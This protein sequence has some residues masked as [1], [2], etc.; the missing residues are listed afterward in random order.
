VTP[1]VQGLRALFL[2]PARSRRS[3]PVNARKAWS[4]SEER[5]YDPEV[6]GREAGR[7]ELTLDEIMAILPDTPRRIVALTEGR[8]PAQLH[9]APS[10]DGWSV[11]D[12]LA[13]LRAC[14]DVLGGNVLRILA[15][16][17]PAW[18]GMNPRAWLKQT[19]YPEWE[20]APGFE[21][22]RHERSQLLAVVEPLPPDAWERTATVTGMV[23]ETY[24]RSA[25]DYAA[26]M[27]RHERSHWA[28][29]ERILSALDSTP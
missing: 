4:R 26:W 1:P 10:P 21:A 20:F 25:R 24:E 27:A 7:R 8:P 6:V 5:A 19:D 11:N 12:V 18:K 3:R 13:H 23:G 9:A 15:E 16:E 2:C 14:H 29:I 28:H 17:H 22:F